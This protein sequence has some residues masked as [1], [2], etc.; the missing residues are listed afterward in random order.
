MCMSKKRRRLKKTVKQKIRIFLITLIVTIT[1]LS[2]SLIAD[3]DNEKNKDYPAYQNTADI[4]SQ[5]Y[6]KISLSVTAEEDILPEDT[7]ISINEVT[8][9]ESDDYKNIQSKLQKDAEDNN[10]QLAGTLIYDLS[11]KDKDDN[12]VEP[13]NDSKIHVYADYE[14]AASPLTENHNEEIALKYISNDDSYTVTDPSD[15]DPVTINTDDN[16]AVTDISMDVH[17][18]TYYALVWNQKPEITLHAIDEAGNELIPSTT[19]E[20]SEETDVNTLAANVEGYAL[21]S[22]TADNTNITEVKADKGKLYFNNGQDWTEASDTNVFFTYAPVQVTEDTTDT[23]DVPVPEEPS[24][25]EEETVTQPVTKQLTKTTKDKKYTVTVTYGDDANLPEGTDLSLKTIHTDDEKYADAKKAVASN[26]NVDANTLGMEA[27]DISLLDSSGNKVEP[28]SKSNV[29]V[30]I[31]INDLPDNINSVDIHH[32][33][34]EDT[35]NT[36][37]KGIKRIGRIFNK[38]ISVNN[39][40][41]S[42]VAENVNVINNTANA[43]FNVN[44]FSTFTVTWTTTNGSTTSRIA[45]VKL[46]YVDE[47][48]NELTDPT[49]QPTSDMLEQ[50]EN[51]IITLKNYAVDTLNNNA[52]R[53]ANYTYK[54]AR[55]SDAKNGTIVTGF[56]GKGSVDESDTNKKNY[57]LKYTTTDPVPSSADDSNWMDIPADSITGVSSSTVD[58]YLVYQQNDHITVHYVDEAGNEIANSVTRY[59]SENEVLATDGIDL[60]KDQSNTDWVQAIDGYT[61]SSAHLNNAL[62]DTVVAIKGINNGNGNYSLQVKNTSEG[63]FNDANATDLY[64]VYEKNGSIKQVEVYYT[65]I[66][67]VP[68]TDAAGQPIKKVYDPS[69]WTNGTHSF[70]DDATSY[71]PDGYAPFSTS[72]MNGDDYPNWWSMN[73]NEAKTRHIDANNTQNHIVYVTDNLIKRDSTNNFGGESL[74]NIRGYLFD[75]MTYSNNDLTITRTRGYGTND[76]FTSLPLSTTPNSETAYKVYIMY[77]PLVTIHDLDSNDT[78]IG[79]RSGNWTIGYYGTNRWGG[80]DLNTLIS[81]QSNWDPTKNVYT[82]SDLTASNNYGNRTGIYVKYTDSTDNSEKTIKVNADNISNFKITWQFDGPQSWNISNSLLSDNN[83]T[84]KYTW[85]TRVYTGSGENDYTEINGLI[86]D[87]YMQYDYTSPLTVT[88]HHVDSDGNKVA[89]DTTSTV[90]SSDTGLTIDTFKKTVTNYDATTVYY[91]GPASTGTEFSSIKLSKNGDKW[92]YA[93][94]NNNTPTVINGNAEIYVVYNQKTDGRA[95]TIHFVDENGNELIDKDGNEISPFVITSFIVSSDGKYTSGNNNGKYIYQNAWAGGNLTNRDDAEPYNNRAIAAGYSF[96]GEYLGPKFN[97]DSDKKVNSDLAIVNSSAVKN[98]VQWY[99]DTNSSQW[100]TSHGA[101]AGT[102]HNLSDTGVYK[103]YITDIYWVYSKAKSATLTQHYGYMTDNTDQT[104]K[105]NAFAGLDSTA[106]P[107]TVEIGESTA[108]VDPA[109]KTVTSGDKTY[110]YVGTFVSNTNNRIAGNN[111]TQNGYN[112]LITD[113]L[114]VTGAR[115]YDGKLQYLV[116]NRI[117][118]NDETEVNMTMLRRNRWGF[119]TDSG[120]SY[121]LRKDDNNLSIIY[122]LGGTSAFDLNLSSTETNGGVT[123]NT[124]TATSGT[125]GRGVVYTV[126]EVITDGSANPTYKL[127]VSEWVENNQ[128]DLYHVY[129]ETTTDTVSV[130]INNEVVYTGNLIADVN[131]LPEGA[132]I[133]AYEWQKSDNTVENGT[134][135]DVVRKQNGNEWNVNYLPQERSWLSLVTD[136]GEMSTSSGRT[137]VKYKARVKYKIGEGEEKTS[138]W[139]PE[140]TVPY[141]DQLE[142]GGFEK[143]EHTATDAESLQYS[144]ADFKSQGIWQTTGLG[145]NA[146]KANT[147]GKDIE[148]VNTRNP[149]FRGSYG[150]KKSLNDGA[151]EGYQFAELNCEAAGALYQDVVTHSNEYL[152]YWLSHRARGNT[153]WNDSMRNDNTYFDTMYLVIMPTS[154]AMTSA[155]NGGELITQDDL[156]KYI[157]NHGGYDYSN[158]NSRKEEENTV[159]YKDTK[160]GVL[161][162]RI[163]SDNLDWH[164]INETNGYIAT[165]SLT[166]FF[167][168]AGPC[169]S[170]NN[171][172]GNFIDDVGL[173]QSLPTPTTPHYHMIVKKT[174]SGLT[175]SEI[176]SLAS[177][178]ADNGNGFKLTI[179]EYS[180]ADGTTQS[181]AY[182]EQDQNTSTTN[183]AIYPR[184]NNAVLSFTSDASDNFT[185]TATTTDPHDS[186]NTVNLLTGSSMGVVTE[187]PLTGDVTMTWT[188]YNNYIESGNRYFTVTETGQDVSNFTLSENISGTVAHGEANANPSSTDITGNNST[189]VTNVITIKDKDTAR[190]NYTNRYR[191][192]RHDGNPMI[193]VRKTFSGITS[194]Q[195]KQML[196]SSGDNQYKVQLKKADDSALNLVGDATQPYTGDLPTGVSSVRFI[197]EDGANGSAILTWHILGKTTAE[198]WVTNGDYTV[199]ESGFKSQSSESTEINGN[200]SEITINGDK[201]TLNGD[202]WPSDKESVTIG[203]TS[204]KNE[205]I[206]NVNTDD[207]E[208][209]SSI[210]NGTAYPVSS[211]TQIIAARYTTGNDATP[212]FVIWT[213]DALGLNDRAKVMSQLSKINGFT[214]L[215]ADNTAFQNG[216][217]DEITMS[218]GSITTSYDGGGHLLLTFNSIGSTTSWT[219]YFASTYTGE[220]DPEV[221]IANMYEPYVKLKKVNADNSTIVLAGAKFKIYKKDSSGNKTY[222]KKDGSGNWKEASTGSDAAAFTSDSNGDIDIGR[223]VPGKTDVVYYFEEIDAPNGYNKLTKPI[224]FTVKT[225]GTVEAADVAD[226]DNSIA[227]LEWNSPYYTITVRNKPGILL[228]IT[229]GRGVYLFYI[230]GVLIVGIAGILITKKK[231]NEKSM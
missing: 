85:K 126:K 183:R 95:V 1:G 193:T 125:E 189:G 197:Y 208:S 225:D 23:T 120:R 81:S 43:E 91:G 84:S 188:L 164:N 223:L 203:D 47:N 108:I 111:N 154:L 207:A 157:N 79:I 186:S 191:D 163:T 71:T 155:D 200:P 94:D 90:S 174:F 202:D 182:F 138:A 117:G 216:D 63:S 167:F 80:N 198:N 127:S 228:P 74:R 35:S 119:V 83:D 156:A 121:T 195:V 148:I 115:I 140:F 169:S 19:T 122:S 59:L 78:E 220:G 213:A 103:E 105:F 179:K 60:T 221:S 41:A 16:N 34:E 201:V 106:Y 139:S 136:E 177:N 73:A 217:Q 70:V 161:I 21:T 13:V 17:G 230:A 40:K 229:G 130:A 110:S 14:T 98:A 50:N 54:E 56:L 158:K 171:T 42:T 219:N 26:K 30:S 128:K 135:K 142:N 112:R 66:A 162:A 93:I 141:Y 10:V 92:Q 185:M 12:P 44:S 107:G 180:S 64:L 45:Q 76:T 144:N 178:K 65:D 134:Y 5:S 214:D 53:M 104:T 33:T 97:T 137:S 209:S 102:S 48:G 150:W 89:E 57:S 151:K 39:D 22:V 118:N 181:D 215:T 37:I 168:V 20:I 3:A 190:V 88:V 129:R 11:F 153:G 18:S 173:S 62:G 227:A 55:L 52:T 113:G 9:T 170:G 226:A 8:D 184:L 124:Y 211:S 58:V 36:V 116:V 147:T 51:G 49:N 109:Q 87:V 25:Q 72:N 28:D 176:A 4:D 132:T 194:H 224:A 166:R 133:T 192:S 145:N 143:P 212:N 196:T 114:K 31:S 15:D 172:V 61:Y 204:Q 96:V 206:I 7:K 205:S 210:T 24:V 27:L 149:K 82:A 165:S 38:D 69:T 67:G 187:D 99:Y 75:T 123:T 29:Q 152:N 199:S 77:K 146:V 100:Y 101:N 159:I 175:A 6:G 131:G 46:H 68:I 86:T 160:S 32:I 222:L 231:L 2:Y 218:N